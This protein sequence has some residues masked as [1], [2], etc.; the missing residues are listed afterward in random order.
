MSLT[1][2]WGRSGS[3]FYTRK[4]NVLHTRVYEAAAVRLG[5]KHVVMLQRGPKKGL[6]PA[7]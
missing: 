5:G 4:N 7:S 3:G 6:G 2:V 1:L